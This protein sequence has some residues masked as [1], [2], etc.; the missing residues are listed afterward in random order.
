MKSDTPWPPP[1][2]VQEGLRQV[3]LCD[4]LGLNYKV[5]V[6]NAKLSGLS[7]HAYLQQITGWQFRDERYYPVKKL[8]DDKGDSD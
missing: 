4:F 7:T 6:L 5:V 2:I 8:H 1:E 3:E